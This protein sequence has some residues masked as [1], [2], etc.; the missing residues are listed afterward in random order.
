MVR[1]SFVS[2]PDSGYVI[3][4]PM[5][6]NHISRIMID[7]LYQKKKVIPLFF[8]EFR[9][10]GDSIQFCNS[11]SAMLFW[12]SILGT[13]SILGFYSGILGWYFVFWG[14]HTM[15]LR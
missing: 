14:Q 3:T 6:K 9:N 4:N 1:L 8:R 11:G 2:F 10:S 13:D 5:Y 7:Y 12:D 15:A